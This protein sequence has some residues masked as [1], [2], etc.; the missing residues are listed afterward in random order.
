MNYKKKV[1]PPGFAPMTP[2]AASERRNHKL[3]DFR[4]NSLDRDTLKRL[5]I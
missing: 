2:R 4:T 5:I 1:T 3:I